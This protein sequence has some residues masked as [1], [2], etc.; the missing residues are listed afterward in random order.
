[1]A[2]YI[3]LI[4]LSD[5]SSFMGKDAWIDLELIRQIHAGRSKW[6]YLWF[7]DSTPLLVL[8]QVIAICLA[9]MMAL[10]VATRLTSVLTWFVTL[11]VCHRMTGLL[12]GL[13][14]VVMML[15][16]YL[17][18][19]P[20]GS[21]WS[22][23]AWARDRHGFRSWFLPDNRATTSTTIAT[24][25]I[26]LHLCVVYLFGGVSKLRGEMWWDGTALWYA[27]ASYEYQ[28]LDLTWIGHFPCLQL[29]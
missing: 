8:H 16:M 3:H 28:S 7:I 5:I 23:D 19:A 13:D 14:Q 12:F 9:L 2:A 27:A 4:W 22:V 21:V 11:M 24:R 17:M 10:G 20:C 1:M 18:L 26:Q 25:L 6:S 15:A 29:Y